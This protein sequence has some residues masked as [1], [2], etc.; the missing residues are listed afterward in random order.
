MARGDQVHGFR[1]GGPFLRFF[2]PGVWAPYGVWVPYGWVAHGRPRERQPQPAPLRLR[3]VRRA[4]RERQ[5][6]P[7]ARPRA[8]PRP[9]RHSPLPPADRQDHP[10]VVPSRSPLLK[11]P[12]VHFLARTRGGPRQPRARLCVPR[13]RRQPSLHDIVA[14]E[15]VDAQRAALLPARHLVA[16]R[17]RRHRQAQHRGSVQGLQRAY[18]PVPAATAEPPHQALT[19]FIPGHR[20]VRDAGR[21]GHR[22]DVDAVA[23]K[24]PYASS[25]G[26]VP[27]P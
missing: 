12:L 23:P 19:A 13:P 17:V 25:V 6:L 18:R 24:D 16:A 2:I 15:H 20:Q 8:V 27:E 10:R 1:R 9:Q 7:Q 14:G 3:Q 21:G 26:D 22:G 4:P 11:S 5:G